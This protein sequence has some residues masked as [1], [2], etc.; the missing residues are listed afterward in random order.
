MEG[1][2]NTVSYA[3]AGFTVIFGAMLAY[4]ISLLVR[5]RNL[6]ADRAAMEDLDQEL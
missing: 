4:L 6:K 5:Y 3:I 1:P 2:A